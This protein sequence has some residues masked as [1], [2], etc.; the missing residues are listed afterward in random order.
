MLQ[1]EALENN[2]HKIKE[3]SIKH[4]ECLLQ[5]KMTSAHS[6]RMAPCRSTATWVPVHESAFTR[7]RASVWSRA[8]TLGRLSESG[9]RRW[10]QK[11]R[12][13]GL[14]ACLG[15]ERRA[16]A[17]SRHGKP[18]RDRP[19]H[20][21]IREENRC[22]EAVDFHQQ[23]CDGRCC[24]A[25]LNKGRGTQLGTEVGGFSMSNSL[26]QAVRAPNAT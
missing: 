24:T 20:E 10:F 1:E 12:K 17:E 19:Q 2:P 23:V 18:C 14:A 15:A 5:M 3:C 9:Q 8:T 4:V 16:E 7:S 13:A 11:Q 21:S 6:N 26:R 25:V 22:L